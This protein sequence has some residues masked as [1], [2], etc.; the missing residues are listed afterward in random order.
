MYKELIESEKEKHS[1]P[2]TATTA[3]ACGKTTPFPFQTLFSYG[4]HSKF[5]PP[6]V[7][8]VYGQPK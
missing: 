7:S 1:P 3:R 4:G 5:L 6:A 8:S 2:S